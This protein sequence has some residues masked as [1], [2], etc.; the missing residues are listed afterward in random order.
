MKYLKKFDETN[1]GLTQGILLSILALSQLLPKYYGDKD[2][3]Y[4]MNSMKKQESK[5]SVFI[6]NKIDSLRKYLVTEID[7]GDYKYKKALKDSVNV[8]PIFQVDLSKIKDGSAE[9]GGCQILFNNVDMHKNVIFIDDKITNANVSATILHELY[10]F[11]SKYEKLNNQ[12]YLDQKAISDNKWL[13]DKLSFV[14]TGVKFEQL[15]DV[16]KKGFKEFFNM[17]ISR[18]SYLTEI[19]EFNVRLL[20]MKN[21]LIAKG[22]I[23]NISDNLNKK[24]LDF[25]LVNKSDPKVGDFLEI[26]PFV[27]FSKLFNYTL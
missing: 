20:E 21:W 9:G 14:A 27:D 13:L 19:Q 11:I 4:L 18:K 7:N 3:E 17:F 10:H 25:I 12:K 6:E 8:I 5:P 22:K 26:L 2:V 15:D 1:E 24:D 16:N 23:K